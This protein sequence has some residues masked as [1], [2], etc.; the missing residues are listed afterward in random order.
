MFGAQPLPNDFTALEPTFDGRKC[1][2]EYLEIHQAWLLAD[3]IPAPGPNDAFQTPFHASCRGNVE[4]AE[5]DDDIHYTLIGLKVLEDKGP[6]FDWIDVATCW[7]QQMAYNMIF[8]AE[9]QAMLNVMRN[10]CFGMT[11]TNMNTTPEYTRRHR[12]PFRYWIGG[13]IRTDG[14]AFAAAGKPELA[15][16][17]AWRDTCWTHAGSGIHSAM[18]YA[19]MQAAA[20]VEKDHGR[21]IE[22]G[23]GQIPADCAL[24]R[25]VRDAQGWLTSEPDFES[26]MDKVES[27]GARMHGAHA[28]VNHLVCLAGPHYGEMDTLDSI[29]TAV[30]CGLDT[31]C[32]GAT[33][34]SIVG[35]ASGQKDFRPELAAPLN[36]RILAR[37]ADF[38]DERMVDLA[39]RHAAIWRTVDDRARKS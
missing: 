21:L 33:V 31:D 6:D 11:R 17:F 3:Y 38:H 15:A 9:T 8:T 25:A 4:F 22:I 37:L 16:D 12:N 28:I 27:V 34:G 36:D 23:L 2:K 18:M 24:A 30:A 5:W 13:R 39:T 26:Y 32:N 14:F 19:A 1:I 35:A 20:F 7:T 10:S 29:T